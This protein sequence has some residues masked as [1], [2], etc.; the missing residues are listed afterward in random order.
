MFNN[1]MWLDV[2]GSAVILLTCLWGLRTLR[3]EA[4]AARITGGVAG[5]RTKAGKAR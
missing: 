5:P 4:H 2:A 3:D 1:W